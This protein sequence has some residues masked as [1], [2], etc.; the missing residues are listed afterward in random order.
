MPKEKYRVGLIG[1]GH[2]GGNYGQ[3]FQKMPDRVELAAACDLI[4]EK[5]KEFVERWEI[6]AS[7]T[8][9]YEMLSKGVKSHGEAEGFACVLHRHRRSHDAQPRAC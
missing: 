4:E 5:V 3:A 6:P 2:I 7:Y 8:D 1:C 9:M